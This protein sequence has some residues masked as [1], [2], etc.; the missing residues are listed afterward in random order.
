MLGAGALISLLGVPA[1]LLG[2][3][4]SLRFGLRN[5]ALAVF[6]LSALVGGVFGLAAMLPYTAVFWLSLAAGFVVQGNFANLTA[7][8]LAVAAPRH[9]GAT[10][11]LYSC[12]GLAAGF[13]G[14]LVFGVT[15]DQ[16]GGAARLGAWSLSFATGGVASLGGA[17]AMAFLQRR[18]RPT[19]RF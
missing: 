3:E 16:F 12:T 1:G 15:L 9:Q 5:I 8:L 13:L 4:L 18:G 19:E 11:A 6:L 7:G 10:T 2:N 17:A 14:T